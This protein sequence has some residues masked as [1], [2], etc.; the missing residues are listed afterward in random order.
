[1]AFWPIK[2]AKVPPPEPYALEAAGLSALVRRK[3][4]RTL[5]ITLKPPD[6]A[7]HISAP[8]RVPDQA[9]RSFIESRQGWIEAH[10][11]RMVQAAS[12]ATL[13]YLDGDRVPL[14]GRQV[15][16]RLKT[17]GRIARAGLDGPDTLVLTVPAGA[18]RP[19]RESA[20]R[21]WYA[22][23][24]LDA[25]HAIL[26]QRQAAVGVTAQSLKIRSMRSRWG[27]CNAR[28]GTITLALELA[29]RPPESLE[30]V[31]VHELAHLLVRSHGKRFKSILDR[32]LPDWRSR[33][34]AL[35]AEPFAA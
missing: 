4:I 7:V 5:R 30:Y 13:A 29:R 26:P 8:L 1:M 22:R 10:R 12:A 3:P 31:L 20:V 2:K 18:T 19:R 28:T 33:R 23:Q 34:K 25:A 21:R 17:Q 24:L 32:H 15:L 11:L 16:L 35:N 9:I 27:S 14:L 6:G